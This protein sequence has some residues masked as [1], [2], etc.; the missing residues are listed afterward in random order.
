LSLTSH[1]DPM[2]PETLHWIGISTALLLVAVVWV[3]V[4]GV[5]LHVSGVVLSTLDAIV[6]LAQLTP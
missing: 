6:D 2:K 3:I 5:A 4:I 1:T